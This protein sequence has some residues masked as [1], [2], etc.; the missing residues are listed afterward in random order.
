M[1]PLI[2]KF[3]EIVILIS[4]ILSSSVYSQTH[5]P[6]K[7]VTF[8]L[9]GWELDWP[10]R[11]TMIVEEL[12]KIQPDVVGLQEVLETPGRNGVD[13]SAKTLAKRLS[14]ATGYNY[15][16][17]FVQTHFAWGRYDEGIA[18]LTRHLILDS[19][20][21]F[22]PAT[23]FQR[24]AL[25]ARI[26]TPEGIIHFVTTHLDHLPQDEPN[27]E[28]QVNA[29]KKFVEEK[30]SLQ[31]ATTVVCGDFN[32]TPA[33]PSIQHLTQKDNLGIQYIDT[34]TSANPN[35]PGYTVPSDAPSQRIDYIFVKAEGAPPAFTAS[36]VLHQPNANNLYPSDHIGVMTTFSTRASLLPVAILSPLPGNEVAGIASIK[37]SIAGMH[38]PVATTLYLSDNA[39]KSWTRLM[40]TSAPVSTYEW[41][42]TAFKDGTRYLLMLVVQGDSSFG[43][44]ESAAPF[45]VN[46]PGNAAPEISL[47]APVG[48]EQIAGEFNITWTA[49]DADGDALRMFLETTTNAGRTWINL[50]S[51]EANDGLYHWNTAAMPNSANYQ[52][53]LIGR[54]D[55]TQTEMIS[56]VF[57]VANPR[58]APPDSIF[59]HVAG[60][61]SGSI[62]A[63]IV[64][65]A[66]LT[67][68]T[69][70]L[71]F[72]DTSSAAK[73]YAAFDEDAQRFVV[74]NAAEL[75]GV[76]EGPAFDGLRLVIADLAQAK[77]DP[78]RTGWLIGH[79]NLDITISLPEINL[80]NM[81]L[82]G[83]PYPAD[84][85]I[86]LYD[87]PVDT[88][89]TYWGAPATPMYFTATNLTESRPIEVLYI[90]AGAHPSIEPSDEIYFIEKNKQ[91]E[92]MLT[93][94]I[95]F[96]GLLSATLPQPGDEYLLATLKPFSH[97]DI[98]LFSTIATGVSS[99]KD[100]NIPL[101]F[102]L[103]QNYPNPFWSEAT[104]R[105]AGNAA[106]IIS[107][108][109]PTR[110][111]VKVDIFNVM[112]QR[113]RTLT[114]EVFAAGMYHKIWD[115]KSD[116][117]KDVASGI[118]FYR[119]TARNIVQ[120]K[121]MVLLR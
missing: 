80:G 104:S 16:Y 112:G 67:G 106:T 26:L 115:G 1:N 33:A 48:G 56:A 76:T 13:N 102:T 37:W 50:A 94:L 29:I 93:W 15:H 109:V 88:S 23:I 12:S 43:L 32:A 52:L 47:L 6:L 5:T 63:N 10:A 105:F 100:Q 117:E 61:G 40:N 11:Q 62:R 121:K 119:L 90:K 38:E 19:D 59:K 54:D 8:N 85:K 81:T 46:N 2:R 103:L 66:E 36:Q 65:Q 60:T 71:T 68:H 89:A 28:A 18:I 73:T 72:D 20:V 98:F 118:Y 84:Y 35:L 69:Y 53:R 92:P 114:D 4:S 99:R 30:N 17:V 24:K 108:V 120:Q 7:I 31:H 95:F 70:R 82:K 34:W 101:D 86:T 75:D 107:F 45:I 116:D 21:R 91:G 44:A 14:I 51:N 42:T 113:V 87:H 49:A 110:S 79:S 3:W 41:N 58:L 27:R 97:R 83:F 111:A 78:G 64:N 22:L 77:V 39:G 96:S 57:S 9:H 25:W 74:K 55:S